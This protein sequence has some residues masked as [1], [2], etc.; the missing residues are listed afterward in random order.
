VFVT[1]HLRPG[2]LSV[3]RFVLNA[4]EPGSPFVLSTASSTVWTWRSA[5]VADRRLPSGWVCGDRTRNCAVQPLLTLDYSV[6][7]LNLSGVAPPGP[8]LLTV[9]VGHL[10]LARA[11]RITRVRVLVSFDGGKT[12]VRAVVT[13]RGGRYRAAFTVPAGRDVTLRVTARDA[14]GS[15]ITETITNGYATS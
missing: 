1:A 5:Y 3:L 2:R 11:I 14:V 6:A 8:Q 4:S 12:W 10:Q 13:G 9:T 7:R 15:R